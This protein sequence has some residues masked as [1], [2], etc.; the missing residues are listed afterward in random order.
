MTDIILTAITIQ[1]MNGLLQDFFTSQGWTIDAENDAMSMPASWMISETSFQGSMSF[2]RETSDIAFGIY[3]IADG[4]LAEV[5]D[6]GDT[7]VA[8][9]TVTIGGGSS[10]VIQN[11]NANNVMIDVDLYSFND[12]A[13]GLYIAEGRFRAY[14]NILYSDPLRKPTFGSR[15]IEWSIGEICRNLLKFYKAL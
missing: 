8:E 13:F 15:A 7:P 14:T 9:A 12:E 4:Q 10:I 5:F 6:V 2:W 3:S 11:Y 1:A